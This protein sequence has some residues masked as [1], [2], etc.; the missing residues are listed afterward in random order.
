MASKTG[1]LGLIIPVNLVYLSAA[2]VVCVWYVCVCVGGDGWVGMGMGCVRV[3]ERNVRRGLAAGHCH[4][5]SLS[6]H[7]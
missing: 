7:S 1:G 4:W 3:A 5:Y 6:S 2:C